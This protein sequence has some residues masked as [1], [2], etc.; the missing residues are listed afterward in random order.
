[1]F[2]SHAFHSWPYVLI[3][4][5]LF[6][7][8]FGTMAAMGEALFDGYFRPTRVSLGL[9]AGAFVGYIGV[10]ALLRWEGR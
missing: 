6:A 5:G 4:A 10:A 3:G 7:V 2:D 8:M 9:A 1:M